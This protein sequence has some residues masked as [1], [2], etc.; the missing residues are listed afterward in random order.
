MK[1]LN[2][3]I[4]SIVD[5]NIGNGVKVHS[6]DRLGSHSTI[7]EQHAGKI[8]SHSFIALLAKTRASILNYFENFKAVAREQKNARHVSELSDHI[9][10]DIGL[11]RADAHDLRWRLTSL[12]TLNA[13]REQYREKPIAWSAIASHPSDL[14]VS[15]GAYLD[16]AN[17]DKYELK[18]CA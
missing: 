1:L 7:Y 13:R 14:A 16:S 9:L 18:K 12:N 3:A 2:L 4:A 11:T 15:V 6:S 5:A 8:R 17:L 10:K